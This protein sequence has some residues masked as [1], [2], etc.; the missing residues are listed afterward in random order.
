MGLEA[1]RWGF[2]STANINDK[3]L[4]GAKASPDVDLR[5][6]ASRD[7]ARAEAYARERGIERAY[8]SYEELL[9]DPEIEAVY[10]SMPNSMHIEW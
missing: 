10:I 2:L 7:P 9:A 5:A 4:P 1:V 3:L 6:V 8:G